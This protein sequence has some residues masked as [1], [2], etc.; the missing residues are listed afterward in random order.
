MESLF[1]GPTEVKRIGLCFNPTLLAVRQIFGIGPLDLALMVAGTK[2]RGQFE[3]RIKAVMD[4]HFRAGMLP[5]YHSTI[6][7]F[8]HS[9]ILPFYHST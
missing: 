9:T 2:Y 3:E 4:Y 8:Y 1:S 6:L 5:F 7:P